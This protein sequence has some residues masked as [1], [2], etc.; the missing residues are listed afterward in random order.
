MS[1]PRRPAVTSPKR[2]NRGSPYQDSPSRRNPPNDVEAAPYSDSPR[3]PRTPT[4]KPK[5]QA[6]MQPEPPSPSKTLHND[7]VDGDGGGGGADFTRKR[8]LIHPERRRVDRDHPNYH[9][10]Q[11][12]QN[13]EV[14]L[15]LQA[16]IRS[17]RTMTRMKHC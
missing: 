14:F 3:I 17:W 5:Q 12:A 10:R 2:E 6:Y 8:S 1:L 9:Y 16:M 7:Q 11:H 13:M 15:R 4:R